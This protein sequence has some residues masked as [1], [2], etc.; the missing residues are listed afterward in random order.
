MRKSR[1]LLLIACAMFALFMLRAGSAAYFASKIDSQGNRISAGTLYIGGESGGRGM[2]DE[3]IALGDLVPGAEP[4]RIE[5]KVKNLG[6]MTAYIN[7]ISAEIA[8]SDEMFLANALRVECSSADGDLLYT[9]SLLALDGDVVPLQKRIALEPGKV[10]DLCISVQLDER[11]GNWYKGKRIEF[12]LAVYAGQRPDQPVGRMA[13]LPDAAGVQAALDA[14]RPGDV[15][16]VPPGRYGL[17]TVSVPGV[18]V[19]SQSVVFDTEVEGFLI[20]PKG[21]GGSDQEAVVIQGFTV[22]DRGGDG[23]IAVRSGQVR[24]ADNIIRS[25]GSAVVAAGSA[26]ACVIR[27]DLTDSSGLPASHGSGERFFAHYNLG[28]DLDPGEH[29]L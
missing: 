8:E 17:L 21:A 29:A 10:E 7:G 11:A 23:G 22:N 19:K 15:V 5:L 27:N 13:V 16:L 24:I 12:S 25:A 3:A 20:D 14:A 1:V 6:T 2:L 4:Y 28:V 9:G 26:K 18:T